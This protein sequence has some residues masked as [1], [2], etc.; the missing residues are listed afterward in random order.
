LE[1]SNAAPNIIECQQV[2]RHYGA[3]RAVDGVDLKIAAG[4]TVGIGGPNGAG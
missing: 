4:E 2:S 1:G 3:L